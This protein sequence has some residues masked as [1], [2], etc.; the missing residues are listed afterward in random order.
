MRKAVTALEG[1]I[2]ANP[3]EPSRA[4]KH[5]GGFGWLC[6]PGAICSV[7]KYRVEIWSQ[8]SPDISKDEYFWRTN[9]QSLFRNSQ[10][11]ELRKSFRVANRRS[12]H[13]FKGK[14]KKL[15]N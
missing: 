14:C 1:Y 9:R 10:S 4:A 2:F 15:E 6:F 3:V 12:D 8:F 5:I 11:K 13:N 7:K